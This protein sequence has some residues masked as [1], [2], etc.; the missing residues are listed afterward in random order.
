MKHILSLIF[1]RS[2]EAIF[3]MMDSGMCLLLHRLS[4]SSDLS[5]Y[6]I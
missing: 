2:A 5:I 4:Y 1:G 6:V 3:V